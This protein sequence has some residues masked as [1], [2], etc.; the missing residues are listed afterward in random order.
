MSVETSDVGGDG[1]CRPAGARDD[2]RQRPAT[3]LAS[4]GRRDARGASGV[5]ATG[6][7]S[8]VLRHAGC[9]V[10]RRSAGSCGGLP[11]PAPSRVRGLEGEGWVDLTARRLN[12]SGV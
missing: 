3:G 12:A 7:I 10:R 2:V 4:Q 6:R 5:R 8:P 9:G 1:R 11:A